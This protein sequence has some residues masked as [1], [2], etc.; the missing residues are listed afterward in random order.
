LQGR[1]F[2]PA[3]QKK[4]A[5]SVNINDYNGDKKRTNV[6]IFAKK[7]AVKGCKVAK[8]VY[9]LVAK[10]SKKRGEKKWKCA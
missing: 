7:M 2:F 10:T 9:D 6:H 4:E 3:N 5:R 1:E 8:R